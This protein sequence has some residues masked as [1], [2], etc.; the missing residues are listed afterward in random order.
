METAI[1][2]AAARLGCG[3]QIDF[4]RGTGFHRT[5]YPSLREPPSASVARPVLP[6]VVSGWTKVP[7]TVLFLGLTSLFT[8]VSSEMVNAILPL[9]LTVALQFSPLQF[10]LVDGLVQGAS[11]VARLAGG[12]SSDRWRCPKRVA[13]GGYGLSAA[14]KLGLFWAGAAGLPNVTMLVLDRIGKGIRTSPRDAMIALSSATAGLAHAFGVHRALDTLGA[15]LGPIVAFGLLALVPNGYD[16]VFLVSF[17]V[18][19]IGLGV[20]VCFVSNVSPGSIAAGTRERVTLLSATALLRRTDF[21]RV[22]SAGLLLGGMSLSDGFVYLGLQNTYQFAVG[23][24]PLLFVGTAF[25][26]LALAVPA[27]R[28]AD[29]LGRTQVFIG[30]H[31]LLGSLYLALWALEE[32]GLSKLAT[33]LVL[34]GAYYAATDGVLMAIGAAVLPDR[35]KTTGLALLT[36]ATTL[37]RFAASAVFGFFW[38]RFG[39]HSALLCF[40]GGMLVALPAAYFLLS[41]TAR[42]GDGN[43]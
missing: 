13:V 39:M 36:T 19:I 4:L 1:I 17:C 42:S 25:V 8:D 43:D 27:G 30:G 41:A 3:P 16:V 33:S 18:A 10:G 9:Y 23:V 2:L 5:M 7:S 24:F 22:L 31:I 14:C 29:R 38:S 35:L 26:Y 34:L 37:A 28:L 40:A 11:A 15:F 21:L 32:P 6:K 12:F 20:L